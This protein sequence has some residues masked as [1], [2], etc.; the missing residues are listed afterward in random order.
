MKVQRCKYPAAVLA[1]N[2]S[3]RLLLEVQELQ[4]PPFSKCMV[5]KPEAEPGEQTPTT[6]GR[7][8]CQHCAQNTVTVFSV[9][10]LP[11]QRISP[12]SEQLLSPFLFFLNFSVGDWEAGRGKGG[13]PAKMKQLMKRK[14][15]NRQIVLSG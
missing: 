12:L 14:L 9:C 15:L 5:P 2:T 11:S 6:A 13:Q 4:L 3:R 7:A 10:A 8:T 1:R